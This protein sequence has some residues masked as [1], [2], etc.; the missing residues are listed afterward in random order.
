MFNDTGIFDAILNMLRFNIMYVIIVLIIP[1]N[2]LYNINSFNLIPTLYTKE[3]TWKIIINELKDK[4]KDVNSIAVVVFR[5]NIETNCIPVV[6]SN[7]PAKKLLI[8]S[9]AVKSFNR[10]LGTS[11]NIIKY[12]KIIPNVLKEFSVDVSN[13]SNGEDIL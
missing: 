9:G 1:C 7:I 3:Y 13:I 10:M 8:K 4:V 11:E 5:G 12:P 6:I 2:S